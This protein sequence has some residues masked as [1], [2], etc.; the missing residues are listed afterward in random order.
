MVNGRRNVNTY[1]V[2]AFAVERHQGIGEGCR[3]AR[4]EGVR[5][6]ILQEV[7]CAGKLMESVLAT[8]T[9]GSLKDLPEM[10]HLAALFR[11]TCQPILRAALRPQIGAAAV[12]GV[13]TAEQESFISSVVEHL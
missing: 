3:E 11:L 5:G 2:G 9:D 4:G 10:Y 7:Y 6:A 1:R 8:S 12:L 13:R